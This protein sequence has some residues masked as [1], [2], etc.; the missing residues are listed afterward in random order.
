[1]GVETRENFFNSTNLD[2]KI[3]RITLECSLKKTRVAN[4]FV[5][6]RIEKSSGGG[7]CKNNIQYSKFYIKD[8]FTTKIQLLSHSGNFFLQKNFWNEIAGHQEKLLILI[9]GKKYS[10]QSSYSG[11]MRL[12]FLIFPF[13]FTVLYFLVSP[14]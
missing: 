4:K 5:D 12:I 14:E 9:V 2:S 7:V 13:R 3:K 8:M 6:G 11:E 10:N 1:M